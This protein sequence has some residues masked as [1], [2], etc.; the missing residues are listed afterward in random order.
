MK[1]KD[2]SLTEAQIRNLNEL[3]FEWVLPR[4][5]RKKKKEGS[6]ERDPCHQS[7]SG[8]TTQPQAGKAG[9]QLGYRRPWHVCLDEV[10]LYKEEHGHIRMSK[11]TFLQSWLSRQRKQYQLRM[12]GKASSL[13]DEQIGKL[14]EIGF[15]QADPMPN[16]DSSGEKQ[17]TVSRT[18]RAE[19]RRKRNEMEQAKR[20]RW[21][22]EWEGE[23]EKRWNS[24][25]EELVQYKHEE[26][27]FLVPTIYPPN[28]ALGRWVAEQRRRFQA[29]NR[30]DTRNAFDLSRE[31]I[32]K[33]TSIGFIWDVHRHAWEQRYKDLVKYKEERGDC[34][35]PYVYEPNKKLGLWVDSQR[36]DYKLFLAGRK[37][38]MTEEK[39][40]LL[41]RI[42][43]VWSVKHRSCRKLPKKGD[44]AKRE[45]LDQSN[46]DDSIEQLIAVEED[47]QSNRQGS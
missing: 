22:K 26:G 16:P 33:L 47:N 1:G 13:T 45:T 6:G 31:Q 4:V 36:K 29:L 25:F 15:G 27:D 43:F 20:T 39:V 32:V 23:K 24:R 35:V 5:Q 18:E 40:K 9:S 28:P 41:E 30:G 11:G 2:S 44:K 8:K 7:T 17:P 34:L 38:A 12:E 37:V 46:P 3:G 14:E 21:Q 42:G 19:C 10:R